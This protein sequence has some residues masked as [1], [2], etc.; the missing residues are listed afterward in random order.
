ME[1]K[2]F[3]ELVFFHSDSER[4]TTQAK[5]FLT[6]LRKFNPGLCDPKDTSCICLQCLKTI[7]EQFDK[8]RSRIRRGDA[9]AGDVV[10][11]RQMYILK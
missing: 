9:W 10:G 2:D 11:V 8:V 3:D 4:M 7:E 6:L 5:K 1:I